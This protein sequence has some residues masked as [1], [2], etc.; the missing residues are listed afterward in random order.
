MKQYMVDAA[1][2]YLGRHA[3]DSV[4]GVGGIV[5]QVVFYASQNIQ[6]TIQ[7]E[8]TSGQSIKDSWSVDLTESISLS[9]R[10]VSVATFNSNATIFTL[11]ELVR[12]VFVTKYKSAMVQGVCFFRNGCISYDICNKEGDHQWVNENLLKSDS[13]HIELRSSSILRES[14]K[15]TG[16]PEVRNVAQSNKI[17]SC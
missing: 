2:K 13:R 5:T 6:L 14:G 16:G 3:K 15:T 4:T 8:D 17:T 7:P 12:H 1:N 9:A 10:K 11:G